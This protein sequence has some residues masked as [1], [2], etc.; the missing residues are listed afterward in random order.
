MLQGWIKLHR[1]LLDHWS[2]SEPEMLATWVR[3]L[4][5][6]NHQDAKKMFNGSLVEIKRGQLIFGYNAFSTKSGVTKKK[7]ERYMKLFEAEG[8]LERQRGSKYSLITIACYDSYQEKGG[9]GEAEGS[10]KGSKGEHRK[11]DKNGKNEEIMPLSKMKEIPEGLN[12]EAWGEW[13]S[14][15]KETKSPYKTEGGEKAKV[16]ELIKLSSGNLLNQSLIIRQSIDNEWKGLFELKGG[17]KSQQQVQQP[18]FDHEAARQREI[19][20]IRKGLM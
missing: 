11:N 12:H 16:N 20:D 6:A 17:S 14:Y 18:S 3:L 15:K 13:L 4:L 9:K 10:Q 1:K 2:A 8:M 19:E 5:E 7:L